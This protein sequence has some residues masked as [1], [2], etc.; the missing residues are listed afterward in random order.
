MFKVIT[1]AEVETGSKTAGGVESIS[2]TAV[3]VRCF[4]DKATEVRLKW[5]GRVQRGVSE[6]QGSGRAEVLNCQAGGT[7][8][9]R[10]GEKEIHGC[11]ERGCEVS[12]CK[13]RERSGR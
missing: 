13:R 5:F 7:E 9:E 11:S 4:G 6:C 3:R 10:K 12:W 8:E 1:G 2:G